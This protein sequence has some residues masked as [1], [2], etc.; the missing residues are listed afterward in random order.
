MPR[1]KQSK[2]LPRRAATQSRTAPKPSAPKPRPRDGELPDEF[3]LRCLVAKHRLKAARAALGTYAASDQGRRNRDWRANTGSADL[4]I[5]PDSSTLNAR[6]RQIVRDTWIGSSMVRAFVRNVTDITVVPHAKDRDGKP[7]TVLNN[8][9]RQEFKR[10][11]H[12]KACDVEHKNTFRQ[13]QRLAA[14]EK[15]T[16]G[17]HVWMW[18]Y[19]APLTP[20]GRLDRTQP[21]GLRLQSFEPEQFDLRVI[22]FE[23]REVRGGVEVDNNGRPISLSLVDAY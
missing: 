20:D 23:G 19:R 12:S 11:A 9:A 22:S 13:K 1:A 15:F 18:A 2:A 16:V 17:E 8:V 6:A 10:W 7:L 14:R 21:V 4:A 3:K 5:I